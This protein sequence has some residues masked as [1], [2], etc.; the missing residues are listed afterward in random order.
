MYELQHQS[1]SDVKALPRRASAADTWG[2]RIVHAGAAGLAFVFVAALVIG[3]V[4]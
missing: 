4:P 3:L 2:R 1:L